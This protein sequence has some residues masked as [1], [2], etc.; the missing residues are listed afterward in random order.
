LDPVIQD[1]EAQSDPLLATYARGS[2]GP[3]EADQLLARDGRR[4]RL[5]CVDEPGII[6]AGDCVVLASAAAGE[7]PSGT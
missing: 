6:H 5:G 7:Y 4:W 2:W 1:W 3:D